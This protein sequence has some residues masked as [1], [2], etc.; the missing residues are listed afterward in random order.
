MSI[1]RQY[2]FMRYF[3]DIKATQRAVTMTT[4]I[5]QVALQVSIVD[6]SCDTCNEVIS[7]V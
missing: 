4:F 3:F 1:E 7:V 6:D 2:L 5:V